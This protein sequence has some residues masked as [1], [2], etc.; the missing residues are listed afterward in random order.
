MEPDDIKDKAAG[1]LV[2]REGPDGKRIVIVHRKRHGG[3]WTLP[4][5]HLKRKE[6][7]EEED[8]KEAALR[9]VAEEIKCPKEALQIDS[10]V[11][12][13]SYLVDGAPKTVFFFNM[14]CKSDAKFDSK[15]SVKGEKVKTENEVDEV[16]LV[17]VDEALALLRY[18][19][20]Q[21]LLRDAVPLSN[22]R[23]VIFRGLRKIFKSASHRR[24]DDSIGAF[25]L[26]LKDIVKRIEGRKFDNPEE[27]DEMHRAAKTVLQ[28]LGCAKR[29]LSLG[30]I[31][32]GWR[33]FFQADLTSTYLL[34]KEDLRKRALATFKEAEAKLVSWRKKTVEELLSVKGDLKNSLSYGDVYDAKKIL[35]EHHTNNYIKLRTAQFQLGTLAMV[36]FVPIVALVFLLPTLS[37]GISFNS[38]SLL[39]ATMMLGALGGVFSGIL[40]TAEQSSKGRIPDQLLSSWLIIA[41][42]VMGIV[43]ALALYGFLFSGLIQLGTLTPPLVLALSFAVGFSERL[44]TR[45]LEQTSGK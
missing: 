16:R 32:M 26:E 4:K 40:S 8:W 43:A 18:P 19:K 5:G 41:R 14:T 37:S 33:Y 11:D 25:E 15:S 45:A 34:N 36:A 2:W 23:P 24:L 39:L 44:L 17:S 38:L 7:G 21:S 3:E 35:Q 42:P 6:N 28:S 29:A 31:E 1:G 20:E 12:S 9:E 27:K 22:Q 10:T 30:K 13:I